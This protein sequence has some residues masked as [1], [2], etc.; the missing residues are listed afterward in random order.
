MVTR[1]S[2]RNPL[3]LFFIVEDCTVPSGDDPI[4][5][6]MGRTGDTN[7]FQRRL[8]WW[9]RVL[10]ASRLAITRLKEPRTKREFIVEEAKQAGDLDAPGSLEVPLH[11]LFEEVEP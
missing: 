3:F 7:A 9:G 10:W 1:I 8:S 4:G 5:E 11:L 2:A 6:Q